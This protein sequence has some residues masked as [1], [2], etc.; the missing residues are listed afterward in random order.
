MPRF[1]CCSCNAPF[2]PQATAPLKTM[3]H[4]PVAGFRYARTGP[5]ARRE[6]LGL[7]SKLGTQW[8]FV[9]GSRFV[10]RPKVSRIIYHR[11]GFSPSASGITTSQIASSAFTWGTVAVLPFYTLMVLAPNAKLTKRTMESSTP[12]VILGVLYA[13]LLHLSWTPD[14]LGSMFASKYW[15]PELPGIAKMFTNEMTLASA[16]IHLLA[17]D[18]FAARQVFHDG[19]KNKV[20][21]RHSVS[22][23]LL[24]CPIGIATHAITK[25]LTKRANRSH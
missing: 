17:V 12:F 8:S 24:S 22:L 21:T 2:S 7:R 15:L 13:Y 4:L 5:V 3:S 10:L 20:E 23:C 11:R 9:G 25:I 14:K 6:A 16:W 1:F 19:L 18:L